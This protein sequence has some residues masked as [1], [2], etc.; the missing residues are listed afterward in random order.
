MYSNK[1]KG[2]KEGVLLNNKWLERVNLQHT[3]RYKSPTGRKL[4]SNMMLE[5]RMDILHMMSQ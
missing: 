5:D 2:K 1:F 4:S 3:N